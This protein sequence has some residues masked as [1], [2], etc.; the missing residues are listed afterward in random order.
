MQ[1]RIWL[2]IID[3]QSR[4]ITKLSALMFAVIFKYSFFYRTTELTISYGIMESWNH[5]GW[6]R[7]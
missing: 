3:G 1:G 4:P 5:L 6:K 7:P 2:K